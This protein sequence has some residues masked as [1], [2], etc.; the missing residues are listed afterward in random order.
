MVFQNF[1]QLSFVQKVGQGAKTKYTCGPLGE[2]IV[3]DKK[4]ERQKQSLDQSA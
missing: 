4:R 1:L 2:E 3:G